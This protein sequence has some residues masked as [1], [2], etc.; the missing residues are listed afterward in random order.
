MLKKGAKK[1]L[2]SLVGKGKGSTFAT[3]KAKQTVGREA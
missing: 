1:M 2:K 3:A